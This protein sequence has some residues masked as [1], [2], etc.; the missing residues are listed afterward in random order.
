[1]IAVGKNSFGEA[2]ALA[3][4]SP[5]GVGNGRFHYSDREESVDTVYMGAWPRK[6]FES[7]G[8]FDE[9]LVRNQDD[10]FNYRLR[11]CG[12]KILLNPRIRSRYTVRDNPRD[13]WNQYF[14]YGFWKVRVFQKHPLQTHLRHFIPPAF[15]AIL[16]GASLLWLFSDFGLLWLVLVAGS[17]LLGNLGTSVWTAKSHGWR[18]LRHLPLVYAI[19]HVSYGLGFLIGFVRFVHRWSDRQGKVP[20]FDAKMS[21]PTSFEQISS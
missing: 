7:I 19:I 5:F 17:Y 1:M 2:A 20:G 6:V 16:I 13:L 10:E 3:T 21:H 9:E 11:R 18:R 12:G 4:S 14:Q 15:I 8:L